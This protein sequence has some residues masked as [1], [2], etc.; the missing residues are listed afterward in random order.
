MNIENTGFVELDE[1]E[2]ME[3]EGGGWVWVV[4][5][6][7]LTLVFCATLLKSCTNIGPSDLVGAG[8]GPGGSDGPLLFCP[9][10][11]TTWP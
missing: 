11:P 4:I 9:S 2:M 8:G 1:A 7:V 6:G 10:D 3:T 5:A